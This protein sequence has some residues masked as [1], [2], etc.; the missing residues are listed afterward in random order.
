[1]FDVYRCLGGRSTEVEDTALVSGSGD[2]RLMNAEA[3]AAIGEVAD[4][5]DGGIP[6]FTGG[7]GIITGAG[8]LALVTDV[9]A[10]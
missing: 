3:G 10:S 1:M 9:L 7:E 5:V 8:T 6:Y 2:L 4:T